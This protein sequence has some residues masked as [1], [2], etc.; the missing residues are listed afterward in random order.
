[1]RA[2]TQH[3]A[4]TALPAFLISFFFLISLIILLPSAL[5]Q[6]P[7]AKLLRPQ[8][9]EI[10]RSNTA[11]PADAMEDERRAFAIS[12]VISL[13]DETRSYSDLALRPRVLAHSAD[14]LW[15][16]DNTTAR[17]LF[18]RAW[19]AAEQG[20]AQD[21]TVKTKDNP[22][23]MVVGLRRLSG[24]DL[25]AE[26]LSLVAR[27]DR[28]LAEE[29]FTKLKKETER[30]IEDSKSGR[31]SRDG[32]S[33]TEAVT[34]RL[35]VAGKLLD[36]GQV[37]TALEF[38]APALD[39][40]NVNSIRF[41][42]A[43]RI[44]SPQLGDQRFALLLARAQFD[45]SSDA[46]TVS[47][48]SSYAFSPGFY[49]T[50]SADGGSRW[51]QGDSDVSAPNLS[52]DLVNRFFEVAGAILR[53]PLLPPDQDFTSAG[54][55]GKRKVIMRLLP[56][57]DQHAPETAAALRAQL[58]AMGGDPKTADNPL[59]TDG[60][61]PEETGGKLVEAMLGRVDRAKTSAERDSIYADAAV[62][63]ASQGDL[64][65]KDVSDKI[66]ESSV[67]DEVRQFV[68]F[69]F[70][71]NSIRK[72]DAEEAFRLAKTGQLSHTQRAW[73][74]TQAGGL[75]TN[76]QPPRS[77]EL[78]EAAMDEA[79]RIDSN[80]ADRTVIL[81]GLAKQFLTVDHVRAWEIMG[82][83][84]KAANSTE[85]FT[86]ENSQIS[87]FMSTNNAVKLVRIGGPDFNL[88]GLFKLLTQ[89]DF[90]RS[91]D[92]AK[93]FKNLGPRATATLAISRAVLDK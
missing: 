11:A 50:F 31:Q 69:E 54:L 45:P 64:R 38:A 29:F 46:N 8:A 13:A 34:K 48:L 22:P 24:R 62:S 9:N 5:A 88:S 59:L 25:R 51:T 61:Q 41:L 44:K 21:L 83:V 23:P 49:V 26:V 28:T 66:A 52:P 72:K 10:E 86:G 19:E 30:E 76:S 37:E 16:V 87:S 15:K 3:T 43:L 71:Q 78:L 33:T 67:R 73:A 2:H 70:V 39:Q 12:L 17:A 32:W 68:D 63:L 92:L 81:I 14:T 27:R 35:L 79:Q 82:E 65:A 91:I 40:V 80:V 60:L 89:D 47:G 6:D 1:M 42:S 75:L 57:F 74:Y 56:L 84:V 55:T 90:Y 7:A 93:S 36:D 4:E 18:R 53:R 77:V 85:L 20:D 58:T